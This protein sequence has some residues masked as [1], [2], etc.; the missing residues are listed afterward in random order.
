VSKVQFRI[1]YT[2]FLRRLIDVEM[3]STHARRDA[4]TLFGQFSSLLI[5]LSLLFSAPALYFSG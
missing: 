2:D 1:L 4:S 5:F 3:L